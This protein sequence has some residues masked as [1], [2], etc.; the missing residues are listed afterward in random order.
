MFKINLFTINQFKAIRIFDVQCDVIELICLNSEK[1]L[2]KFGSYFYI[3]LNGQCKWKIFKG[4]KS[5]IFGT[6][7]PFKFIHRIDNTI[8]SLLKILRKS[9]NC[10]EFE[11]QFSLSYK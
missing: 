3:A 7:K 10:L 11:K 9:K 5:V 6:E 1:F 2:M 8:S 4:L